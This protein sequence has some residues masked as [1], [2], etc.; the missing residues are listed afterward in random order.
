[1]INTKKITNK[2][3]KSEILFSLSDENKRKL[4]EFLLEMYQD[5]AAVCDKYSLKYMLG[6]GSALGAVRHKGFIPWDDDLDIMM[7]REDYN[8]LVQKFSK[9]FPNKY[10]LYAP[11]TNFGA[12]NTFAKIVRKNTQMIDIYNEHADYYKGVWIDIFPIENTYNNT[13]LRLS[14]ALMSNVLSYI[15]VS[16]YIYE[17]RKGTIKSFFSESV[18]SKVNFN[19]RISIGFLFSFIK[20][21][22][23]YDIFDRFVRHSK[24]G[25]YLTIPTG[26][27]HYYGETQNYDVF[28]PVKE[29]TFEGLKA[30]VPNKV[31][32]YLKKLYGDYMVIPK[33]EN[34][35][36]HLIIKFNLDYKGGKDENCN[37]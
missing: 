17:Y 3:K 7:H 1:M 6:G 34:R 22:K 23:L 37:D 32:N 26:R 19:F 13:L 29:V 4:Q 5:F 36:R 35:E 18:I 24:Q 27:K 15:S 8:I 33:E 25:K 11:N 2:L 9:E 14:K 12:S 20:Y 28:F 30:Y 21:Q 16:R 10:Y 31:E